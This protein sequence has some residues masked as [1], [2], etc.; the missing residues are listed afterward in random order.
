[1]LS[2]IRQTTTTTK[3]AWSWKEVASSATLSEFAS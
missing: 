3:V 1:M 2:K